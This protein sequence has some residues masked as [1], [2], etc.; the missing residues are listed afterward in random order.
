MRSILGWAVLRKIYLST[1]SRILERCVT[2][3]HKVSAAPLAPARRA[4]VAT[5]QF[6]QRLTAQQHSFASQIF[7]V[8]TLWTTK[9]SIL[10]LYMRLSA[11]G[12]HRASWTMLASS[13]VWAI[14]SIILIAVPCNPTQLYNS[15]AGDCT[16]MVCKLL[17]MEF[18]SLANVCSGQNGR[19]SPLLTSPQKDLSSLSQFSSCGRYTC[20]GKPSC[21]SSSL[22]PLVYLS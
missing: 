10:L 15:T 8:L 7:Y 16:D 19:L 13:A 6:R 18:L 14:V 4:V 21:L 9:S 2:A 17:Y 11:S 5:H 3:S 20:D 12:T 1:D 22:S